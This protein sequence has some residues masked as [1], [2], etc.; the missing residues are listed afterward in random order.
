MGVVCRFDTEDEALSIANNTQFGLV[1][2]INDTYIVHV[3]V[4]HRNFELT[5]IKIGFFMNF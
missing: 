5:S 3:F 2:N 1:G 4:L